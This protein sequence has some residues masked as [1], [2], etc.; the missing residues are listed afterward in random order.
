[1][2]LVASW[3]A[4]KPSSKVTVFKRLG[5]ADLREPV[6]FQLAAPAYLELDEDWLVIVDCYPSTDVMQVLSQE[7]WALA[8]LADEPGRVSLAQGFQRGALCWSVMYDEEEGPRGLEAQGSPPRDFA[9]L[10]DNVMQEAADARRAGRDSNALFNAPIEL[11]GRE[12]G[13][14]PD[15]ERM[16]SAIMTRLKPAP[17]RTSSLRM[18]MAAA[19]ANLF[20]RF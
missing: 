15:P 6:A 9:A 19:G 13:F 3:I 2:V 17:R 18:R 10:A 5:L 20:G 1:M 8:C 4:V 11:A 14:W 12:C 7:G 16:A